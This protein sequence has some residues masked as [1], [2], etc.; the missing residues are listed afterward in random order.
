MS[1]FWDTVG[2][3]ILI[4]AFILV[5]SETVRTLIGFLKDDDD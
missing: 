5:L 2:I 3:I 1:S 4:L